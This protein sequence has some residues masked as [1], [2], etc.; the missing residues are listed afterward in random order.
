MLEQLSRSAAAMRAGAWPMTKL[1]L[2]DPREWGLQGWLAD[3][4]PHVA[5]GIA[6]ALTHEALSAARVASPDR[7]G[8]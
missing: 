4:V 8:R 5:C 2:T 3:I 7:R 6:T 1:G